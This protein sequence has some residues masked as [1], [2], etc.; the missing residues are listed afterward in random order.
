MAPSSYKYSLDHTLNN[1]CRYGQ[2]IV[3]PQPKDVF[4]FPSHQPPKKFLQYTEHRRSIKFLNTI[5]SICTILP[6]HIEDVQDMT[7][8]LHLQEMFYSIVCTLKQQILEHFPR[9]LCRFVCRS[10]RLFTTQTPFFK[11]HELYLYVADMYELANIMMNHLEKNPDLESTGVCHITTH[12]RGLILQL[13]DNFIH[14]KKR[15]AKFRRCLF[16]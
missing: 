1:R 6:R 14:K 9:P 11:Q 2:K 5:S 16:V 4:C 8:L 3:A 7:V 13:H 10:N 15:L 12:I